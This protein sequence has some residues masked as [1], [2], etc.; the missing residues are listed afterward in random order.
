MTLA[1]LVHRC[2]RPDPCSPHPNAYRRLAPAFAIDAAPPQPYPWKARRIAR[3]RGVAA[4][5]HGN[6]RF[7]RDADTQLT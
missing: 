4:R 3:N 6:A 5:G 2:Q 7:G 1:R